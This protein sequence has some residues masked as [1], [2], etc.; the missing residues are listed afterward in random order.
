ML[1][2]ELSWTPFRLPFADR[3]NTARGQLKVREGIILKIETEEGLIGLGEGSPLPEYG[4]GRLPEVIALLAELKPRLIGADL[5]HADDEIMRL[6]DEPGFG[7]TATACA[8]DTAVCDILSQRD[9]L[10]LF[11]WLRRTKPGYSRNWDSLVKRIPVNATISAVA[12][13]DA[14]EAAQRAV[15]HG[16]EYIKL[17]V[18]V[19]ANNEQEIERIRAVRASLESTVRLRLD[20][21]GAWEV[22][23]AVEIINALE[24]LQIELVEQPVALANIAG[25][26]T[27]REAVKVKIAA[28]EPVTSMTAARQIIE[29]KAA[30]LLVIK[31]MT[32][33]G[34]RPARQIIE[35]A[36]K[37][38]LESYVTTSFDSGV[39]IMAALHLA[40]TLPVPIRPCGLATASL[41]AGTLIKNLPPV[42]WGE[43]LLPTGNGLGV[44]LDQAQ[45]EQFKLETRD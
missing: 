6:L 25:L 13:R 18:G 20:A 26:A 17:K 19:E 43:M 15:R 41:L 14:I 4:G 21:N 8:L 36:T 39:G 9:Q 33:G 27:V 1:I 28:D 16:F 44:E 23:Q 37:A 24:D 12:T 31:P 7:H 22:E 34:L 32:V 10:P 3:F 40:A 29:H 42:E 11:L 35:L 30:D 2:K 38:G 5:K 45:L